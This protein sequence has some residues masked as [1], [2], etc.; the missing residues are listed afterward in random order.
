[1]GNYVNALGISKSHT[2]LR[3]TLPLAIVQLETS[4]SRGYLHLERHHQKP[5]GI[6]GE[7]KCYVTL[8]N[9]KR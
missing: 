8:V 9:R 1:M 2:C 4:P 7:M 6:H 5:T 3:A